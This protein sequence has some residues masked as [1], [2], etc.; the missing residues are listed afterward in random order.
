MNRQL[1]ILDIV[2]RCLSARYFA[3][4]LIASLG[5]SHVVGLEIVIRR[6]ERFSHGLTLADEDGI[7]VELKETKQSNSE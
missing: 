7:I 4:R 5:D 1:T 6:R 3:E 2:D